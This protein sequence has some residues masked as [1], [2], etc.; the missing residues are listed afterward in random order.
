[1]DRSRYSPVPVGITPEGRWLYYTGD[2]DAIPDGRWQDG[3]C[4]PCTLCL[5]RESRTLLL[6]D[7]SRNTLSL[8]AAFPVLHGKNGEDGT[9][10]GLLEL[11]GVPVIGC[12][13]LSSALCMDKDRSHK[14][15]ALA[16]VKVPRSAVFPR[17]TSVDELQRA[18]QT[19]GYPLFVKPVRAGSSFG[20]S[21]VRAPEELAEAA[22]CAFANDRELLLEEAIPGF[23]VSCAVLGT[24]S[25]TVG[26]V[27]EIELSQGFFDFEEK[28]TLKTSAIHCPARIPAEKTAEI[29]QAAQTIYRA[30]DCKGF[31]RVDLFLTPEGSIIFNEVNTIP[32]F[33]AHSRY[34]N[35]MR[36]AG[37]DFTALISRIIETEV[38]A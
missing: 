17:G 35:M 5:D 6:L 18:A 10:Q 1:M 29:R 3:P 14:L 7:G 23:E 4:I 31:A 33:T 24:E 12:G 34:P 20:V 27:D 2:L 9:L 22:A 38:T 28:Y 16:G 25:L 8:D 15:A 37:L 11:A 26:A 13:V 19:L 36:A 32:G 30:L 21:M